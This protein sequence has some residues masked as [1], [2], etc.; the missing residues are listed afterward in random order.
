[1]YATRVAKPK[2]SLKIT[3]PTSGLSSLSL[4]SPAAMAMP[5]TPHSPS[6]QSPTALNTARNRR[7]SQ[8]HLSP[9]PQQQNFTYSNSSTA[10]SILKK[11]KAA[12]NETRKIQFNGEPT[13]HCITPIENPDEYYGSSA[14][15]SRE[16]KR[17]SRL[18]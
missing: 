9:L 6:P 11:S 5:R 8:G 17:W 7:I 10:K 1:M 4:P 14:R 16:E 12:S 13:V 15:M 2:L 3:T 18:S